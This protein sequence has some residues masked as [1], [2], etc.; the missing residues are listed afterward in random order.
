MLKIKPNQ[1]FITLTGSATDFASLARAIKKS[2]VGNVKEFEVQDGLIKLIFNN[3]STEV[4]YSDGVMLLVYSESTKNRLHG[5]ISMPADTPCG[6]AFTISFENQANIF[7]T[8]ELIV[9]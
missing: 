3:N 7:M 5:L 6:S 9:E 4:N 1:Q 8:L 2:R